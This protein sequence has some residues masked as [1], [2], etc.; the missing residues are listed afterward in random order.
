MVE[1]ICGTISAAISPCTRRPPD[2]HLRRAGEA[3]KGGS[4]G[5][6][7]DA[8]QKQLLVAEDVAEPAAGD[9][10]QREGERIAGDDPLDRRIACA[11][12]LLDR[13]DRD[14]D[15]GPVEHVHKEGEQHDDQRNR[16]AALGQTA[17]DQRRGY[18][19]RH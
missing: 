16:P 19:F 5:K 7:D 9:Q 17:P 8:C 6:A 3:A 4:R 1:R 15:D 11:E 13:G 2:Q 10:E 18:R 14:V 12:A